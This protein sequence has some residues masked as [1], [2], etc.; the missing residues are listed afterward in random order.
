MMTT[1]N[2]RI[3]FFLT[4]VLILSAL[5]MCITAQ[6]K[7]ITGTAN[8]AYKASLEEKYGVDIIIDDSVKEKGIYFSDP[9]SVGDIELY[10][11][12]EIDAAFSMLP[13]GFVKEVNSHFQY[14]T[15]KQI[16]SSGFYEMQVAAIA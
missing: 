3:S 5:S 1:K 16:L 9:E 14:P 8:D 6:A 4:F 11:L 15:I 7:E 10:F 13:V 2:K 12:K